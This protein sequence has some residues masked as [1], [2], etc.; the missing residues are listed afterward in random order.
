MTREMIVV[1]VAPLLH[2]S[3]EAWCTIKSVVYYL[4]AWCT[5]AALLKRKEAVEPNLMEA[6][7]P[8]L[9]EVAGPK[10]MEAV[11][12]RPT[13]GPVLM[14]AVDPKEI[15]D[16]KEFP[17]PTAVQVSCDAFCLF[18]FVQR[19]RQRLPTLPGTWIPAKQGCYIWHSSHAVFHKSR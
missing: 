10:L 11:D 5:I 16:P 7:E 17:N 6:V 3:T 4:K 1:M 13:W 2:R 19:P 15:V 12:P 18:Y 14:E 8:N 9:M